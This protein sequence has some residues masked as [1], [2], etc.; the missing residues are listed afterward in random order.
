MYPAGNRVSQLKL[1]RRAAKPSRQKATAR[2][3][4]SHNA[5]HACSPSNRRSPDRPTADEL[6]DGIRPPRCAL[7]PPVGVAPRDTLATVLPLGSP[8]TAAHLL[9]L[10]P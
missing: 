3:P 2:S 8:C 6:A 7:P 5:V 4:R 1:A 10:D 9:A